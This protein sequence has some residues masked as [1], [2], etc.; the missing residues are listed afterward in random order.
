[1][2]DIQWHN[3]LPL[4]CSL[5]LSFSIYNILPLF[6]FFVSLA[7]FSQ[8]WICLSLLLF[9]MTVLFSMFSVL[10]FP[11]FS[12]SHPLSYFCVSLPQFSPPLFI[13]KGQALS[14]P[15]LCCSKHLDCFTDCVYP[16]DKSRQDHTHIVHRHTNTPFLSS[17][18]T[19][20]HYII[21][22]GTNSMLVACS[23]WLEKDGNI[24]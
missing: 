17:F 15:P 11:S 4:F 16:P 6:H 22:W 3:P 24:K 12:V 8:H 21:I 1:M 20:K 9:F 10:S 7:P 14:L 23:I 19:H 13:L 18:S 5:S 2:S